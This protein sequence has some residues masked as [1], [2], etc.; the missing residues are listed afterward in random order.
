MYV[1]QSAR[2]PDSHNRANNIRRVL[3][4]TEGQKQNTVTLSNENEVVLI[5]SPLVTR[6]LWQ[7]V[8]LKARARS[9]SAC[10]PSR[11]F[12]QMPHHWRVFEGLPA[13]LIV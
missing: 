2:C 8:H 7:E 13:D 12:T 1:L 10:L 5:P 4:K 9:A 6:V 11:D 3:N